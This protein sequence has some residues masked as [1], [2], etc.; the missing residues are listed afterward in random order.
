MG[1]GSALYRPD[2]F[3]EA[4]R[5]VVDGLDPVP[6]SPV[7]IT[8]ADGVKQG[9]DG[10]QRALVEAWRHAYRAEL[11]TYHIAC[12]R[13]GVKGYKEL[14]LFTFVGFAGG[15]G[16]GALL[17]AL[18]FSTSAIGEWAVRALSG[19]GEDLAEGAWVL[20]SKSRRRARV[21][22]KEHGAVDELHEEGLVWFEGEAAEAYGT[23]KVAGMV[24]PWAVDALSRMA[25]VDVRAPEGSYVAY[26]YSLADQLFASLNGLRYH[27]RRAGGLAAGVR[28][29]FGDPV[30][31]ASFAVVT[32][33]FVAL[34][35]ARSAGWRPDLLVLAAVEAILLNLCWAPPLTAW[36]WD[37]HLQRGLRH[38]ID[39]YA[40]KGREMPAH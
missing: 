16:L 28:S 6:T 19:E 33:P 40:A 36:F 37:W 1:K 31:V 26:F 7:V 21:E 38:I 30:M 23:G 9:L 10:R 20:R 2:S 25:G 5:R 39:I 18:G 17:D 29:Y 14:S 15:L 27:V 8:L 3:A 22:A 12:R 13:T 4:A 34:F 11:E 32:L 24:F 35:L